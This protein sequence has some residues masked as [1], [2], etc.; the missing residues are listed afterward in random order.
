MHTGDRV[1]LKPSVAKTFTTRSRSKPIDW[2]KRVGE[3][4][5]IGRTAVAIRWDDR[6]SLDHWPIEALSVIKAPRK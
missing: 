6:V 4:V 1:Q 5:G 2:S 3:V